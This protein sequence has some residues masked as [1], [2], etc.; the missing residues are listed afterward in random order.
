MVSSDVDCL[1]AIEANAGYFEANGITVGSKIEIDRERDA[2]SFGTVRFHKNINEGQLGTKQKLNVDKESQLAMPKVDKPGEKPVGEPIG[3]P[4]PE[5]VDPQDLPIVSPQ[6]IGQYLEDTFDEEQ[7]QMTDPTQA[8]PSGAEDA[9]PTPEAVP[10]EVPGA[11]QP[12]A[13]QETQTQ[14]PHFSTAYEAVNWAKDNNEAMRISYITK[15]GRQLTRDIEPH[16]EFHSESTHRQILVTFDRSV[17]SIRAFILKNISNWAFLGD[18]FN[19]KF[20]VRA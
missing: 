2:Y 8:P 3:E 11:E 5:Q 16:G 12:E 20:V 17:G 7:D 15:K 1:F 6:D 18:K 10:E 9:V 13:P 14:Y 4:P 19:K